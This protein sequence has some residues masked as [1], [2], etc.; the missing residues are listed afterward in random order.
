MFSVELV[1]KPKENRRSPR[2]QVDMPGRITGG[3]NWRSIC[4]VADLSRHG[5]RLVTFSGLRQG[6]VVW[7][8]LPGLPARKGEIVWAD[9]YT[10]ACKFIEPLNDATITGLVARF[11]IPIEPD[12]LLESMIMVA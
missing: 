4:R 2:K 12:R 1:V 5:A 6:M 7:V 11:G 10:A 3:D 9:D 8:N